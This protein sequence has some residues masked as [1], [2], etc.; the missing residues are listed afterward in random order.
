MALLDFLHGLLDTDPATRWTP[1]QAR[2]HPFVRGEHMTA[3]FRPPE[4]EPA[5]ARDAGPPGLTPQQQRERANQEQA[6]REQAAAR[7]AAAVARKAAGTAAAVQQRQQRQLREEGEKGGKHGGGDVEGVQ[8]KC[9]ATTKAVFSSLNC[10]G[11]QD[12]RAD[13]RRTTF[14]EFPGKTTFPV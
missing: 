1:D 14:S 10:F 4:V 13:C 6:S 7:A 2:H 9:C 11:G 5:G 8:T 12:F 3:P